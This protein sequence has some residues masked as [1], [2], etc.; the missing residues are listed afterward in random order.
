MWVVLVLTLAL[1]AAAVVLAYVHMR[2]ASAARTLDAA[3][4]EEVVAL[5]SAATDSAHAASEQAKNA[6]DRA[7]DSA[8]RGTEAIMRMGQLETSV[9]A[10]LAS[11]ESIQQVGQ[12][13]SERALREELA[14]QRTQAAQ[15]AIELRGE[16]RSSVQDFRDATAASLSTFSV[17]M[18]S[19]F[20]AFGTRLAEANTTTQASLELVRGVVH[21]RLT[22]IQA[23]NEKKLEEMRKTVDEKLNATLER[24]LGENFQR[25]TQS[26]SQVERGLGEMRELGAGVTD[27]K[28]LMGNVKSRGTWGEFALGALLE[29]FLNSDQYSTN[30]AAKDRGGERVEFAV[31]LPGQDESMPVWLPIDSKFPSEDYQRLALA[32]ERGDAIGVEDAAKALEAAVKKCARDIRDKYINPP[33]TTD[34]AILFLPTEGLYAEVLRRPGLA[35]VLQREMRIAVMGPTTLGAYINALQMG[36]RTLAVQKKSAEVWKLLE[37]VKKGF[38]QFGESLEAVQKKLDEASSKLGEATDRS[39]KIVKR[40]AKVHLDDS[41]VGLGLTPALSVAP[42]GESARIADVR[43]ESGLPLTGKVSRPSG[44]LPNAVYGGDEE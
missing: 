10:R 33:R 42:L 16:V 41:V 13:S 5:A 35:D 22:A 34:W 37:E 30:F 3:A 11:V 43:P 20:T 32:A 18:H 26:L 14:A 19:Q 2:A 28:R 27:L 25:V 29:Q 40:L 1:A 15:A 21:E 31:R 17:G 36:F 6:A 12:Q 39:G 24:R 23:D 8:Q 44:Y 38:G 4:H 7:S 9:L